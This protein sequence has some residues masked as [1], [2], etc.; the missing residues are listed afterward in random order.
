M[1]TNEQDMTEAELSD[2]VDSD[3]DMDY[4]TYVEPE[5]MDLSWGIVDL[6]YQPDFNQLGDEALIIWERVLQ[7]PEDSK[8]QFDASFERRWP[9]HAR[10]VPT[11]T[12][13]TEQ[14]F[15]EDKISHALGVVNNLSDGKGWRQQLAEAADQYPES[16]T[17]TTPVQKLIVLLDRAG[18]LF[19]DPAEQQIQYPLLAL[20]GDLADVRTSVHLPSWD[21]VCGVEAFAGVVNVRG[22]QLHDYVRTLVVRSDGLIGRVYYGIHS[23]SSTTNQLTAENELYNATLEQ[24]WRR[25]LSLEHSFSVDEH[26]LHVE[27]RDIRIVVVDTSTQPST[28][29]ELINYQYLCRYIILRYKCDE[30]YN[31]I[32][33]AFANRTPTC[34]LIDNRCEHATSAY[35][36]L[37]KYRKGQPH[38]GLFDWYKE[39]QTPEKWSPSTSQQRYDAETDMFDVQARLAL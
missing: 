16:F 11:F 6:S 34:T 27:Y 17:G 8:T 14:H 39:F 18:F 9:E 7:R 20:N 12:K 5:S 31:S 24:D 35:N 13:H 23:P 15:E 1:A 36:S 25:Y 26:V 10:N 3:D 4:T 19:V 30:K 29:T 21:D 2:Y 37:F 28:I 33:D 38:S 22:Q 32:L